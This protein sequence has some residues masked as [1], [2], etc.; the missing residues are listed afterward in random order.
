MS[1]QC[2]L[3]NR[4][5]A[6]ELSC[7]G[8]ARKKKG[9]YG[10]QCAVA[11]LPGLMFLDCSWKLS[12][13]PLLSSRVRHKQNKYPILFL[14]QGIS[15]K[16]PELMDIRCQTTQIAVSFAQSE[17]ILVSVLDSSV[18]FW[19]YSVY[20]T[21]Q[22]CVLE[23][24]KKKKHPYSILRMSKLMERVVLFSLLT[25]E[26]LFSSVPWSFLHSINLSCYCCFSRE[27]VPTL[28]SC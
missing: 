27:S 6:L 12:F 8:Q 17:N 28:R 11:G 14:T 20:K 10:L 19:K 24:K 23:E 4:K 22:Y 3:I 7:F 16:Y 9:I 26:S 5:Q 13:W 18:A 21:L 2:K 25:T 15:E 1:A